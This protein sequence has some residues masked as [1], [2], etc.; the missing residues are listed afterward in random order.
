[1]NKKTIIISIFAGALFLIINTGIN[2]L[3]SPYIVKNVGVEA[4]GFYSLANEF[5]GYLTIATIALNSLAGRFVAIKI[6]QEDYHSANIYFSSVVIA[7]IVISTILSIP[8]ILFILFID[9]IIRVPD[10]LVNDVRILFFFVLIN[11]SLSTVTTVFGISLFVKNK[12]YLGSL[13]GIEGSILRCILL[14]A[15]FALL[16][17]KLYYVSIISVITLL[18]TIFWNVYYTRKYLPDLKVKKE[19]FRV[20]AIM[21]LV[22]SGI[23]NS[24][25]QI[26]ALLLNGLDIL[27]CNLFINATAMGAFAISITVPTM[28]GSVIGLITNTFSP[29]L[30]K[31]Y[32]KNNFNNMFKVLNN[33]FKVLNAFSSIPIAAMIVFGDIFYKL[34]MPNQDSKLLYVLSVLSI[35]NAII[36]GN[37]ATVYQIFSVVNRLKE[38][39]IA[40]IVSGVLNFVIVVLLI[41][42]T[43]LGIYAVAGVS[44]IITIIRNVAFTFPFTAK[45]IGQKWNAFHSN[46]LKSIYAI[47]IAVVI[48]GIFR[49]FIN[50]DTWFKLVLFG[51]ISGIIA[52]FVNVIVIF[53]K[54]EK[55]YMLLIITDKLSK[56]N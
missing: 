56:K 51:A 41:K 17:A 22:S 8:S 2:L 16:P 19:Y 46:I 45:C 28:L 20:K 50:I 53:T 26:G 29:D 35:A 32:A 5:V 18:Y 6:H 13:R 21:E 14:V 27:I 54:S 48:F 39:S 10:F 11:F 36:C 7:N 31:E 52:L 30:T 38:N 47:G 44:S 24:I 43:Q 1:M 49:Y 25:S 23:W 33:S 40:I 15:F 4:Y 12:L 55:R 9:K 37:T 42:Y 34:W 3:L